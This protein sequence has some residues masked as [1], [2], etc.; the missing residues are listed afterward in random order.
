MLQP[1]EVM[2]RDSSHVPGLD[3]NYEDAPAPPGALPTCSNHQ[4]IIRVRHASNKDIQD[5][6]ANRDYRLFR[7]C[8]RSASRGMITR[9]PASRSMSTM[10]RTDDSSSKGKLLSSTTLFG[11]YRKYFPSFLTDNLPLACRTTSDRSLC[12]SVCVNCAQLYWAHI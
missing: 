2:S 3:Q 8:R 9:L 6:R 5:T 10:T 11:R 1:R 4:R 7:R 12:E